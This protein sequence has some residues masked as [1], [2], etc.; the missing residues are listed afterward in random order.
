MKS[1]VFY[2]SLMLLDGFLAIA[3]AVEGHIILA[4]WMAVLTY[5][6][7]YCISHS[8]KE[9]VSAAIEFFKSPFIGIFEWLKK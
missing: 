6:M 4:I 1:V 5:A 7:Y 8:P 2:I 9:D 3:N